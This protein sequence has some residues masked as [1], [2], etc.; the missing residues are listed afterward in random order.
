MHIKVDISGQAAAEI[1][2]DKQD[3]DGNNK[4]GMMIHKRKNMR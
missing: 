2:R 3:Q 4:L 1:T